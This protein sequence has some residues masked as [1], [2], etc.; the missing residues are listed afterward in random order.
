MSAERETAKVLAVLPDRWDEFGIADAR[1]LNAL[2]GTLLELARQADEA[3]TAILAGIEARGW[4]DEQTLG[5]V[6]TEAEVVE[7]VRIFRQQLAV[8]RAIDARNEFMRRIGV[9][10]EVAPQWEPTIREELDGTVTLVD[11]EDET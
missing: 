9:P 5:E 7:L 6:A 2:G 8:E 11:P 4:S 10:W 1:A 3:E